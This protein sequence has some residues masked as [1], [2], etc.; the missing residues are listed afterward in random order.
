MTANKNEK[1]YRQ[2]TSSQ[3]IL[4]DVFHFAEKYRHD[5]MALSASLMI[6]AKTIYINRLG[7]EQTQLMIHLFADNMEQPYQIEKVTLH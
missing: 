3:T 4:D 7:P 2:M 1:K 5:P 6:V